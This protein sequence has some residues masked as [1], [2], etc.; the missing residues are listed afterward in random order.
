MFFGYDCF[1]DENV[2]ENIVMIDNINYLSLNKGKFDELYIT[3]DMTDTTN[4]QNNTWCLGNTTFSCHFDNT[5]HGGNIY[6]NVHVGFIKIKRRRVGDTRWEDLN[7]YP[8]KK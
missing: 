1:S 4:T 3:K 6:G 5:S 2:F 8:I 7:N